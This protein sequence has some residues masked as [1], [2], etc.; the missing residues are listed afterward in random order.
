MSLRYLCLVCS[1][2]SETQGSDLSGL[3]ISN[4]SCILDEL[5]LPL[6]KILFFPCVDFSLLPVIWS[7]LYGSISQLASCEKPAHVRLGVDS[8]SVKRH[9]HEIADNISNQDRLVGKD[10][11]SF[12]IV[13]AH[14]RVGVDSQSVER[15]TAE[16]ADTVSNQDPL[17][18]KT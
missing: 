12:K 10:F 13:T 5:G 11:I 8:Q 4:L 9:T 3:L 16:T 1:E 14:V 15:L 6:E 2:T 17:V 18:D 7:L